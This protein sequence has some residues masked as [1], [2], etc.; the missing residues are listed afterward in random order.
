MSVPL[1]FKRV[2]RLQDHGPDVDVVRRKLGF[3]S[4]SYDVSVQ[5]KVIGLA[6]YLKLETQGE[7]NAEIAEAL[8]P[9]ADEDQP[10]VWYKRV[11]EIGCYGADVKAFRWALGFKDDGILFGENEQAAVKR[12]QSMLDLPTTGIVDEAMSKII[13]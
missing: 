8:G 4:G 5:T 6:D 10:P 11:L 2:I 9:A 7:L 3:D 12:L 1:W 13:R